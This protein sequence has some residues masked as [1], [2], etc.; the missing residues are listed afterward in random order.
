MTNHLRERLREKEKEVEEAS[1]RLLVK[2]KEKELELQERQ[3]GIQER[4]SKFGLWCQGEIAKARSIELSLK[5]RERYYYYYFL[6]EVTYLLGV[7]YKGAGEGRRA[8]EK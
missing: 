5:S 3:A 4:E 8:F 7:F 6:G 1:A 2:L